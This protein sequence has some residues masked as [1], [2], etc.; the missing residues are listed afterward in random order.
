[1]P[2]TIPRQG[3]HLVAIPSPAGAVNAPNFHR[4]LLPPT[5]APPPQSSTLQQRLFPDLDYPFLSPPPNMSFLQRLAD[6]GGPNVSNT[7]RMVKHPKVGIDR[8]DSAQSLRTIAVPQT[9]M[10]QGQKRSRLPS[11]DVARKAPHMAGTSSPSE[12]IPFGTPVTARKPAQA[13]APRGVVPLPPA[14]PRRELAPKNGVSESITFLP[15]SQGRNV[16]PPRSGRRRPVVMDDDDDKI[17]VPESQG[18]KSV[19][20]R[21][22]RGRPLSLRGGRGEGE[23]DDE[24]DLAHDYK[25]ETATKTRKQLLTTRKPSKRGLSQDCDEAD[26]THDNK[27]TTASKTRKLFLTRKSSQRGPS[28][29]NTETDHSHDDKEVT[30]SNIR[31]LFLR[32]NHP[33]KRSP[34]NND[35]ET[36][37]SHDDKDVTKPNKGKLFLKLRNPSERGSSHDKRVSSPARPAVPPPSRRER[38]GERPGPRY[39]Y[40]PTKDIEAMQRVLGPDDWS[41]YL[42]L[43]ELKDMGMITEA[44]YASKSKQIFLVFDDATRRN[45]DKRMAKFVGGLLK[46][47]LEDDDEKRYWE[48]ARND[49]AAGEE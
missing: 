36:G 11:N 17:E 2:D 48:E 1:M 33:S 21:A 3:I 20:R 19:P 45:I 10:Q 41:K 9:S 30:W 43:V 47:Y 18:R 31:K 29:D 44:K 8:R 40:P 42:M 13:H 32:M 26:C 35:D 5:L 38:E 6:G 22:A 28:Q 15:T 7:I 14:A 49:R 46:T 4:R 24:T 25:E 37:L 27:G 34:S 16:M 39:N 12:N 23:D